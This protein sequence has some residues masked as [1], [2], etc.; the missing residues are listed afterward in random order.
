MSNKILGILVCTI[1]IITAVLPASGSINIKNVNEKIFERNEPIEVL[2]I[3]RDWSI[4]ATYEIPEGA[5][6]L[7]FDGDYLYCGIYGA[8]GDE[9][10]QIDR[11]NGDYELEFTGPQDDAYGLTYD[12]EYLW[13][14]HHPGSSSDPALA[15]QL[16]WDG[17]LISQFD[18]PDHYMSGIAYDNGDFWVAT[19]YPDP[20]TI[21]KVDDE[22]TVLKEF[23]SPDDQPW[24]VCLQ[25]DDLWIADYWGDTLYKIYT[26]NGTLIE[27]H[28]SEGVDPAGIVWDGSFLWYCDNGEDYN[29]DYLYKVDLTGEGTPKINLPVTSHY[30]G[31]VT[32]NDSVSWNATVENEGSADLE[33]ENVT[34]SE[35]GSEYLSCPNTFPI[36]VGPG[37]ET[38]ITLT[39]EPKDI[40]KLDAIASIESNDPINP[41]V[42][43]TLTGDAV[44]P[45]PDIFLLEDEYDYGSVRINAYTRWFLEIQ[46]KGDENLTIDDITSDDSHF[47]IDDYVIFP[48]D[49]GVLSSAQ[50]GIWFQPSEDIAY[51]A[52]LTIDSNDPDEDPYTVTVQGSGLEK[53]YPIGDK[54]WDF[55]I[56]DPYDSSPK[57][58]ASIPDINGDGFADVIICSEDD[59]V[60]CFNGN[61]HDKGDVLW[62][63]EIY[64]GPVYSQKG[65]A[66]TDDINDDGYKD[67]VIGSAWGGRLIRT[68]SGKTGEEIWTHDT[69]EYG[70]GGWVYQVDCSYDYND[71]GV[72]DVLASTGDDS[73]DTGPKRVYCLDGEDGTSIWERFLS[74]PVFSVIGIEDFTGDGQPDVVAGCS[75]DEETIGYAK[76]INGATGDISWTFMASGT[77]V[78]ALEQ[79]DDISDDGIKDVIIGDFY[80]NI[81]GLNATNGNL[82]YSN[83]L[84]SVI[85]TRFAKLN[86][87][88]GDNHPDIVPAHSTSHEI[89]VID[90]QT[91]SFVWSHTVAD[92]PWNV[93]RTSDISGDGIDDVMV[94]TLFNSNFCYFL[95]GTDGSELKS[96]SF[97]TPVDAI[98]AIPDIVGDGSMEMI[99]GGRNGYVACFSGGLDVGVPNNPPTAPSIEGPG[100]GK[101]G[102]PYDYDFKSIDPDGDDVKYYIDWGDQTYEEWIGPFPSGQTVT[103]THTWEKR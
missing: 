29:Y 33:L 28:A 14:T 89:Q 82:K 57:A 49:I 58:I 75:N 85:I 34:F 42:E 2:E 97:G 11:S 48:F 81:Y 70:D 35:T 12:G 79:I 50:V 69:H 1:L 17:S 73:K 67:V 30:Y 44:N 39:Y 51:S 54:L 72:L 55:Q 52:T 53:D 23:T 24:D 84:G 78:W 15:L 63:H 25:N 66:I 46:N 92:Q 64:A 43:I 101:A 21:Y 8:N 13:T 62:E 86:D 61:A 31:V 102:T 45:G 93:A 103:R 65:L 71:D 10:Y 26:T 20:S 9:I 76:G 94:G 6:G 4:L 40:G 32:V 27:S 16:D 100:T 95:N 91:G 98:A 80:G 37:N 22:G 87:V 19:Y 38:N 77:S 5:S 56:V 41:S 18:L 60:R 59:Y 83:S 3:N 36:T 99:A 90:G 7:A 74:G 88:N 96:I 47:T 68:I